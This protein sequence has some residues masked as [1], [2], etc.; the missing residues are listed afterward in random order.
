M[1]LTEQAATLQFWYC[2]AT[3]YKHRLLL[4]MLHLCTQVMENVINKE[5]T[6]HAI[7][8]AVEVGVCRDDLP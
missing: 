5:S 1:L 3:R 7:K 4:D 2:K 8:A 6:G